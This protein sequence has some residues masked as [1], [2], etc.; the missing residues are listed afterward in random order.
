MIRKTAI[1]AVI[2]L[3]MFVNIRIA[4]AEEGF[5]SRLYKRIT[6]KEVEAP[7]S[8]TGAGLRGEKKVKPKIAPRVTGKKEIVKKSAGGGGGG[9]ATRPPVLPVL[10]PRSPQIPSR[11]PQVQS[12]RVQVPPRPPQSPQ[13]PR[14]FTA[15]TVTPVTRPPEL[16]AN[17]AH[18][19]I[20]KPPAVPVVP[21][22][23]GGGGGGAPGVAET[24]PAERTLQEREG[25]EDG[26]GKMQEDRAR[27]Y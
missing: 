19:R 27:G 4:A 8:Q 20:P 6:K 26:K 1:F 21:T 9:S 11:P 18:L 17:P 10:P 2:F 15:P 3:F 16:P 24:E 13:V 12:P 7:P 5:F 14:V 22:L 25:L 23:P